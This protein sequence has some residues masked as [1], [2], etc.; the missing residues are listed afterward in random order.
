MLSELEV[1]RVDSAADQWAAVQRANWTARE[2]V[3]GS[4]FSTTRFL[5]KAIVSFETVVECISFVM[6]MCTFRRL[7][8][9]LMFISVL[10]II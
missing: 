1:N 2:T 9:T 5:S 7:K 10:F 6:C 4:L 3:G 8:G